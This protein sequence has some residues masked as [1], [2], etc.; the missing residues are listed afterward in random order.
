[1]M[2]NNNSN[3]YF[4]DKSCIRVYERKL[5]KFF[6]FCLK[7]NMCIYFFTLRVLAYQFPGNSCMIEHVMTTG[8]VIVF[9]YSCAH[10]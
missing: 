6:L 8:S 10:N 3:K 5:N 7:K 4:I 1:M 9:V 2:N